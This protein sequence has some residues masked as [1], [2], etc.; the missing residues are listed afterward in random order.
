MLA[1]SSSSL[2]VIMSATVAEASS[3]SLSI[4]RSSDCNCTLCPPML[5]P[6]CLTSVS[7]STMRAFFSASVVVK[8]LKAARHLMYS[9]LC[10]I[11]SWLAPLPLEPV[12]DDL[13]LGGRSL[14]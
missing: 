3:L 11:C 1:I 12:D 14:P 4:S 6:S 13:G 5:S 8:S 2:A 10:L 7:S 9:S